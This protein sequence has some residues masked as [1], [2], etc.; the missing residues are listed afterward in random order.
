MG[1]L[2]KNIENCSIT[3]PYKIINT[4]LSINQSCCIYFT[5]TF[6]NINENYAFCSVVEKIDKFFLYFYCR[7]KNVRRCKL[8]IR[9]ILKLMQMRCFY[10]TNDYEDLS[11][12]LDVVG[13]SLW[14]TIVII[15]FIVIRV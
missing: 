9:S 10:Q 1:S 11:N 3:Y 2:Y 8:E 14:K 5:Y 12:I 7:I 13:I 15:I 6:D 4:D